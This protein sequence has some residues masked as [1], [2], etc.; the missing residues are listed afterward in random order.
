MFLN[1]F[2][3]HTVTLPG[4]CEILNAQSCWRR[5]AEMRGM[6]GVGDE[7]VEHRVDRCRDRFQLREAGEDRAIADLAIDNEGRALSDFQCMKFRGARPSPRFHLRRARSLEQLRFVEATGLRSDLRREI[8]II[9]V[10]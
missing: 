7:I 4:V 8:P 10:L 5:L 9:S 6:R 1:F 3:V 2:W